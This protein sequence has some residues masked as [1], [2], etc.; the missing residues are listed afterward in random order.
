M[1][2]PSLNPTAVEEFAQK[3]FHYEKVMQLHLVELR[4]DP[5]IL[6]A[7]HDLVHKSS[8]EDPNAILWPPKPHEHNTYLKHMDDICSKFPSTY[9]E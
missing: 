8:T 2:A 9:K 3:V 7:T 5:E 6:Q 1:A 4:K